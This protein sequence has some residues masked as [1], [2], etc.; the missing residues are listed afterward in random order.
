MILT[1]IFHIWNHS[2]LAHG[3]RTGGFKKLLAWLTS[4]LKFRLSTLE[5]DQNSF[6]LRATVWFQ[7]ARK[8]FNLPGISN[9]RLVCQQPEQ[10]RHPYLGAEILRGV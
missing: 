9:I 5:V 7:L 2:L 6:I 4:F 10:S 8:G 1:I 3:K